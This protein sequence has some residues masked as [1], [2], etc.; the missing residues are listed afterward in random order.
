MMGGALFVVVVISYVIK[1][2]KAKMECHKSF[3]AS[4]M[5]SVTEF[6]ER[7]FPLM[8]SVYEKVT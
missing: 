2:F 7:Y 3:T 5:Y 4:G 8:Y 6:K 1:M